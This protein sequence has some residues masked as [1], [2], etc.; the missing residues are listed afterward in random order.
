MFPCS[1]EEEWTM[2]RERPGS[3]LGPWV[4]LGLLPFLSRILLQVQIEKG[5]GVGIDY[6]T[7]KR[8]ILSFWVE[9]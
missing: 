7:L 3:L 6:P 2:G 8:E 9:E 5:E 4:V 1:K